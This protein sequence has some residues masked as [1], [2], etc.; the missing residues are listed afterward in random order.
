MTL[1]FPLPFFRKLYVLSN[2]SIIC[3][4]NDIKVYPYKAD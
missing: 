3:V 1:I 2:M 4:L